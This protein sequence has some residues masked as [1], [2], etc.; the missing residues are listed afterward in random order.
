MGD[1]MKIRT[2]KDREKEL[3]DQK[4]LEAIDDAATRLRIARMFF[5]NVSDPEL[6]DACVYEI[7]SL[8][9]HYSFLLNKAKQE[10]L[11]SFR[12]LREASR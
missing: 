4:L 5:E 2:K 8:Q 11:Q 1:I 3:S 12:Y 9:A 7:N 6:I 10:E